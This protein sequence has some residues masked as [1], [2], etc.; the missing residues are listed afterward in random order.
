MDFRF[1]THDYD[2][3]PGDSEELAD[4]RTH[5]ACQL[6]RAPDKECIHD[7]DVLKAER[8]FAAGG[9]V[10]RLEKRLP[11]RSVQIVSSQ[12]TDDYDYAEALL[13]L[14]PRKSR[15]TFQRINRKETHMVADSGHLFWQTHLEPLEVVSRA[16]SVQGFGDRG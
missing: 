8:I 4:W 13:W 1:G 11:Q 15:A 6:E 2:P 14:K 16:Y 9:H 10:E 12:S 7:L 5:E 3:L